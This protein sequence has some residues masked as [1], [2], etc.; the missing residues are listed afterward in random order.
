MEVSFA[1][2]VFSLALSAPVMSRNADPWAIFFTFEIL[3]SNVILFFEATR[4][5]VYVG[6]T[7]TGDLTVY[8]FG[9][10]R[11]YEDRASKAC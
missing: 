5:L 8:D 4:D 2:T 1:I 3:V 11:N 10:G 6:V 7:L 9:V